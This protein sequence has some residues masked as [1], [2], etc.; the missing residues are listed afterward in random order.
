MFCGKVWFNGR[1]GVNGGARSGNENSLS[2]PRKR[3]HIDNREDTSRDNLTISKEKEVGFRV[4]G[5]KAKANTEF[6][7]GSCI[8]REIMGR[9]KTSGFAGVKV[10]HGSLTKREE[11]MVRVEFWGVAGDKLIGGKVA[12]PRIGKEGHELGTVGHNED[13]IFAGEDEGEAG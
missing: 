10:N 13:I 5:V 7:G 2:G 11:G 9:G 12:S 4:L 6:G 1:E 8:G 3:G